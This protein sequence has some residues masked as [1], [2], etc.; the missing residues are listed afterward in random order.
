MLNQVACIWCDIGN[1]LT[2]IIFAIPVL[3]IF[4]ANKIYTWAQKIIKP[5]KKGDK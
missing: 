2:A 1:A 4:T 3:L 5:I